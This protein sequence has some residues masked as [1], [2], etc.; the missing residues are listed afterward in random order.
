MTQASPLET[1]LNPVSHSSQKNELSTWPR[2]DLDAQP[3]ATDWVTLIRIA[4]ANQPF[5]A[6]VRPELRA[7]AVKGNNRLL[8][9]LLMC[10]DYATFQDGVLVRRDT[11]KAGKTLEMRSLQRLYDHLKIFLTLDLRD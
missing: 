11:R 7:A 10:V 8:P 5:E 1:S 9:V 2:P 3:A 6:I 4:Q